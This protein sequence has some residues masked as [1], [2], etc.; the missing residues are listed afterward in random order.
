MCLRSTTADILE[1]HLVACVE[2]VGQ[3]R[4]HAIVQRRYA[5]VLLI[6]KIL[7]QPGMVWCD[8]SR[9][10]QGTEDVGRSGNDALIDAVL[11]DLS[12][13]P[14]F[15]TAIII[16]AQHNP[17]IMPIDPV[18]VTE[19]DRI[20]LVRRRRFV[21]SAQHGGKRLHDIVDAQSLCR[22]RRTVT[23]LQKELLYLWQ[24]PGILILQFQK[25]IRQIVI[26]DLLSPKTH[27]AA[28]KAIV[29]ATNANGRIGSQLRGK[30]QHQ[31]VRHR[32]CL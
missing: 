26:A 12:I 15:R 16:D 9:N 29:L 27:V 3:S 14:V 22:Q 10:M 18:F 21:R 7:T 19:V 11:V 13:V 23:A 28:Y 6:A 8:E 1:L 32:L 20:D 17:K 2:P 4:Q 24:P 31:A 5:G 30:F 25:S